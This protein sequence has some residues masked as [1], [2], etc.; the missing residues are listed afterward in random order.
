MDKNLT[1][2]VNICQAK[3]LHDYDDYWTM[4]LSA[5]VG[6]KGD[7]ISVKVQEYTVTI[8]RVEDATC[9]YIL[10]YNEENDRKM[11]DPL[12]W[13]LMIQVKNEIPQGVDFVVCSWYP[14][15]MRLKRL[16]ENETEFT[17]IGDIDCPLDETTVNFKHCHMR[18]AEDC[19]APIQ[20][21]LE[22]KYDIILPN[23]AEILSDP[24]W[25]DEL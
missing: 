5:K 10:V 6:L 1:L 24:Y 12:T 23:M 17:Y 9:P 2:N 19:W 15:S 14:T 11:R 4:V 3:I 8:N 16:K 13:R 25:G 18:L 21:L 20:M 7:S 22:A